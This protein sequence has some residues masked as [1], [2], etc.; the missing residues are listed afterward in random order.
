MVGEYKDANGETKARWLTCGAVF[1]K[2]NGKLSLKIDCIPV[3]FDGWLN[4]FVPYENDGS[5]G[6]SSNKSNGSEASNAS[7]N[8]GEQKN[9]ASDDTE[10]PF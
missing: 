5:Y 3:N 7:E 8:K 6:N 2:D 9:N 4:L 1:E 10:L